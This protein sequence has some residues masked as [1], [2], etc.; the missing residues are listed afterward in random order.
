[1]SEAVTVLRDGAIGII[2]LS[3]PDK[4]NCLSGEMHRRIDAARAG[5]EADADLRAILLRGQG[6]HFCTGADLD[7]VKA[8][9]DDA[10]ALDRFIGE[11]MAVLRRLETS[12][13]PVIVAVQGLCLAGGLELVLAADVCIAAESA[14]FGDQH[15]RFGL[16]PGWGGSQRLTRVIGL[17]RALDLMLSARWMTALEAQA[18]GLVSQ[19]VPDA[20]LEEAAL[21]YCRTLTTR[22]RAGLALMK[23]LG[24]EGLEMTLDQG[25]RLERDAALRHLPGADA[26]EGLAAFAGRRAPQ[27][28]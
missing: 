28:P 16:I 14:S 20:G 12:P 25:M 13:L 15:A 24:R 26:A 8:I 18:V 4:F 1:M 23:R 6:R 19:V 3:R 21:D 11:G 22:S 17:R 10:A 2:E 27:F 9:L 5:F 7:E